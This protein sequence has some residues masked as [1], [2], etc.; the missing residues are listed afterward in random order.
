MSIT[1]IANINFKD[2]FKASNRNITLVIIFIRLIAIVILGFF[3]FTVYS[4]LDPEVRDLGN[5]TIL[6]RVFVL[7]LFVIILALLTLTSFIVSP[8]SGG[9]D[10]TMEYFWGVR[11]YTIHVIFGS[12][13]T[14]GDFTTDDLLGGSTDP[15]SP[16]AF[17]LN[18]PQ[19]VQYNSATMYGLI[20]LALILM[21][22]T[23]IGFI[24]RSSI[25]L[26]GATFV[27]AQFIISLA[28]MKGL[29]QELTLNIDTV[30]H[31]FSSSL[32]QLALI[33]YIYFE[34]SLQTG[35]IYNLANPTKTRQE[36]VGKQLARLAEFR[37]GLTKLG[38]EEEVKTKEKT[39]EEK[40]SS[41]L[42][43]GAGSSTARK[44]SADALV[45]LLEKSQ[46]SLFAKPGGEQERLTGRL[47]RFHDSLLAHDKKFD[48]KLGG[49]GAK[50][51][52]IFWILLIVI[53][54]T[55]FRVT[56][57]VFFAWIILNSSIVL[58][59]I[60]LPPSITNSIELYQP[61]GTLVVL[62]PLIF[63]IIGI[64]F[65]F[66]KLQSK[67]I[68][69]EELIISESEV[70]EYIKAGVEIKSR[71]EAEKIEAERKKV[72]EAKLAETEK[73]KDKK[74]KKEEL[75]RKVRAKRKSKKK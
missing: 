21:I 43:T 17:L 69:S 5:L 26:S 19:R 11:A 67:I 9:S 23:G 71:K 24:R 25:E 50:T 73:H 12:V 52:N 18:K 4:I 60:N 16:L 59:Y 14:V 70:Q 13:K 62:I 74:L 40:V 42:A 37:L 10:A 38:G 49:S 66:V 20:V 64:S 29:T 46:D 68:K 27:L 58:G 30:G 35:Y 45:F 65:L 2:L 54:S 6:F 36:R 8:L 53:T 61:E 48:E 72:E 34:F 41:A 28:Y 32:F 7:Y 44:F 75:R 3:V 22:F 33:S 56:I 31:L 55:I 57:L 1:N 51:F 39:E 47:Q 63:F 15:L